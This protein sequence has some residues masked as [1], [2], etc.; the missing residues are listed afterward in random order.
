MGHTKQVELEA[1]RPVDPVVEREH[2]SGHRGL[3]AHHRQP[4]R[5]VSPDAPREDRWWWVVLALLLL[6]RL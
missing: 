4:L 3:A 2:G 6:W 1:R 5:T